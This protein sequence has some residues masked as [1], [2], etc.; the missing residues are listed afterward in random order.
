MS[1]EHA[2]T[3]E[4]EDHRPGERPETGFHVV[5]KTAPERR[6]R[7]VPTAVPTAAQRAAAGLLRT[8]RP[9]IEPVEEPVAEEP[10][11]IDEA[12]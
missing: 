10:P 4:V 7:P 11:A 12:G 5:R 3:F 8:Q 9:D 2:A 1:M 6:L